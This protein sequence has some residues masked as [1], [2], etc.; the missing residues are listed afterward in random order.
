[1]PKNFEWMK[2]KNMDN[3]FVLTVGFSF[4]VRPNMIFDNKD[5]VFNKEEDL[6][7]KIKEVMKS[8]V[9]I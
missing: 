4:G 1:M 5:F 2:I 6:L 8:G 9:I 7:N 3:G